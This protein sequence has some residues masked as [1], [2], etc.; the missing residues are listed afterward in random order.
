MPLYISLGFPFAKGAAGNSF[1][2]QFGYEL[3]R[4]CLGFPLRK[5]LQGTALKMN[6]GTSFK[7]FASVFNRFSFHFG[8]GG[9]ILEVFGGS[10]TQRYSTEPRNLQEAPQRPPRHLQ[11]EPRGTQETPKGNPMEP[12]TPQKNPSPKTTKRRPKRRRR[13]SKTQKG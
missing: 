11:N 2:E 5:A 9:S 6:S 7:D 10:G 4:S 3:Q 8:P 1:E 12:K 13:S